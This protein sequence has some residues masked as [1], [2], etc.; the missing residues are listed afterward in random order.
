MANNVKEIAQEAKGAAAVLASAPVTQ[1]NACLMHM[2]RLL[3]RDRKGIVE[4]NRRDLEEARGAGLEKRLVD[5]LVFGDER[6]DSR[7]RAL[8]A[9][10]SLEDPTGDIRELRKM[11]SGLMVGRMS[12]PIGV[13]GMIYESRPHVTVN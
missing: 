12:V 5:R 11:P 8:E 4:A 3:D 13:I 7:I 1:K 10:A 9:I 6:V 2:A